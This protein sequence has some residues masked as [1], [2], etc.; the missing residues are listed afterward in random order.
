M[1]AP[2]IRPITGIT[3]LT[4]LWRRS[5]IRWPDGRSDATTAVYWMQTPSLFVD[6]RQ[7]ADRPSFESVHCLRDLG[8]ANLEWLAHQ[9]GFAGEVLWDG[10]H[11]EWLRHFDFQPKAALPDAGKLW[12]E[13][14]V[15][16]EEGRDLPYREHWHRDVADP[17]PCAGIALRE[18]ATG[19][20]AMLVRAGDLFM[21][22]RARRIALPPL[23]DLRQLIGAAP[24]EDAMQDL[25]D[26]EISV[27]SVGAGCWRIE[28]SSLP[29]KERRLL[30]PT[31]DTGDAALRTHDLGDDGREIER[32]WDLTRIEGSLAELFA[33]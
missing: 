30:Q 15:M 8:R 28:H 5:L 29:F 16:M 7:P 25:V 32:H 33:P 14:D 21:Y 11:I 6:L 24:S 23:S 17:R 10:R 2:P 22:A 19:Q 26:C 31:T 27:G 13:G 9:E 4:G 12:F 20:S 18:V 3:E 1:T